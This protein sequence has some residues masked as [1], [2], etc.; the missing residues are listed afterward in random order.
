[1]CCDEWLSF[2]VFA[3]WFKI[4]YVEG[5]HLDKDLLFKCNKI[6]SPD[7]TIFIPGEIIMFNVFYGGSPNNITARDSSFGKSWKTEINYNGETFV[8]SSTAKPTE[9]Q[10]RLAN[11]IAINELRSN[12]DTARGV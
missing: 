8:I 6:Y 4:A 7:T 12:H 10:V 3:K 1:M 5:Y 9:R 2:S 11:K